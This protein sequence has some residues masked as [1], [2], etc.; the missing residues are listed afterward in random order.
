[1]SHKNESPVVPPV[2]SALPTFAQALAQYCKD[3]NADKAVLILSAGRLAAT[4]LETSAQMSVNSDYDAQGE[5]R[6]AGGN[7][8]A[9]DIFYSHR[10]KMKVSK[11]VKAINT[12]ILFGDAVVKWEQK[13]A[14]IEASTVK[15]VPALETS[16]K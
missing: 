10:D 15:E 8:N 12:T 7:V 5:T 3:M 4:Y 13:Q 9:E 14:A 1:M 16:K 11:T 6:K 2:P